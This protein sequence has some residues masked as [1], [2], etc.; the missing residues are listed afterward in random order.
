MRLRVITTVILLSV[1]IR[2]NVTIFE[3]SFYI[4]S[5]NNVS[6]QRLIGNAESI[7]RG[8]YLHLQN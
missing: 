7:S 3:K 2:F 4:Q 6:A 5:V 8:P 1:R